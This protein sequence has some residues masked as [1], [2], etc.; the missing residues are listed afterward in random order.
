[1]KGGLNFTLS[2]HIIFSKTLRSA[3]LGMQYV[4]CKNYKS[5]LS[6]RFDIRWHYL[7]NYSTIGAVAEEFQ[8]F[9]EFQSFK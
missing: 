4:K 1:M 6:R 7:T 8:E 5:T 2:E 9:Q 3:R